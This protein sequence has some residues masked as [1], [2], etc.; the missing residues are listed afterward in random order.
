[1]IG[2]KQVDLL[3][4]VRV[5][6][7]LHQYLRLHQRADEGLIVIGVLRWRL[8]SRELMRAWLSL[9][10][11]GGVSHPESWWGPDC[12]WGAP[13]ASLIRRADEG[14]IVI[15]VLRWRLSSGEL[16]RAWLSLGCSGGVSHPESWWGPDCHWGAPV[17]SLIR[18]ADEGLIV[19]GVL[20]WRLSSRFFQTRDS[21]PH[22]QGETFRDSC[23]GGGSTHLI[24]YFRF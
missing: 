5:H 2:S 10:C 12:H 24:I 18:R 4:P 14:L 8:S 22:R 7:R 15:G 17:A 1:M 20:R 23:C 13:V 9:G 19:I 11:S 21:H 3:S 16:M 6:L